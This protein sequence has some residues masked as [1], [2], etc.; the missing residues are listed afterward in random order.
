[1]RGAAAKDGTDGVGDVKVV[2]YPAR[3]EDY[4]IKSDRA[5]DTIRS[6][7]CREKLEAQSKPRGVEGNLKYNEDKRCGKKL[8]MHWKMRDATE[9]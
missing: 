6:G 1:V 2:Q 4:T 5:E 9:N 3:R 7:T 8:E